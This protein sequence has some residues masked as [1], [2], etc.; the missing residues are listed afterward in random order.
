MLHKQ[1]FICLQCLYRSELEERDYYYGSL[2][3]YALSWNVFWHLKV[4]VLCISRCVDS[5]LSLAK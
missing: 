4:V 5:V 1:R 2:D 3:V